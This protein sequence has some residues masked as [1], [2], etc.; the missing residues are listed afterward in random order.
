MNMQSNEKTSTKRVKPL[1]LP[2]LIILNLKKK[3][4]N[5]TRSTPRFILP[6]PQQKVF[7]PPLP[8]RHIS[9]LPQPEQQRN[10]PQLQQTFPLNLSQEQCVPQHCE[11]DPQ[12]YGTSQFA[13]LEVSYDENALLVS[14]HV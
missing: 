6:N 12:L 8:L 14:L 10:V 1:T 11:I 7:Q 13:E 3:K 2:V 5:I 9:Q 4:S